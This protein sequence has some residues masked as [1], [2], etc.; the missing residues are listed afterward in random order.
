MDEELVE[1]LRALMGR[2]P[3]DA[4]AA[5]VG[6]PVPQP[7]IGPVSPGTPPSPRPARGL[8]AA[9]ARSAQA[10]GGLANELLN[11]VRAGASARQMVN[12]AIPA[13]RQG[14]IGRAAGLGA[15]A[16]MSVPGVPGPDDAARRMIDVDGIARSLVD[17]RGRR[18]HATDEGVRN[19]WRWATEEGRQPYA[20]KLGRPQ[21]VYHGSAREFDR[22][23]GTPWTTPDPSVAGSYAARDAFRRLDD[24][25]LERLE[26]RDE[27]GD[28]SAPDPDETPLSEM[29]GAVRQY[30]EGMQ[31]YPMYA[32]H[33]KVLD[34]SGLGTTPDPEETFAFLKSK[35]IIDADVD[36]DDMASDL[37]TDNPT[38][39]KQIEDWGLERDF[40]RAGFDAF[41]IDDVAAQGAG[42]EALAFLG[43]NQLKS[44]IGN[45]GA[46]SRT[47]PRITAGILAALGLGSQTNRD[48]P[49]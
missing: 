41:K 44:A 40:Q 21:Q 42:H 11:P 38:L 46:F 8:L 49:R 29:M 9:V 14:N 15:L 6:R 26:Y 33:R 27:F 36:F 25:A 13:A 47:D 20:D 18:L 35:G 7:T 12:E 31:T 43:E 16:A 32:R 5:P 10:G 22:F 30:G 4:T 48:T 37:T 39:W 28:F 19:F 24:E 34:L 17:A 1:R 3:A 2:V 45:S 23:S